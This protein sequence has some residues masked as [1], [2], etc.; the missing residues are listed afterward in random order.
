MRQAG[1]HCDVKTPIEM[2]IKIFADNSLISDIKIVADEL[3]EGANKAIL[4]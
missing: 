3:I 4:F 2:T 1:D